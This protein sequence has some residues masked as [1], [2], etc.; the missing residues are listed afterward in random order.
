MEW[1]VC[2]LY[3]TPDPNWEQALGMEGSE[4]GLIAKTFLGTVGSRGSIEGVLGDWQPWKP[5]EF[6]SQ[7]GEAEFMEKARMK[8][9]LP[10]YLDGVAENTLEMWLCSRNIR[11]VLTI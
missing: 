1:T 9:P 6:R 8:T 7:E 2:S 4:V 5:R 10:L 11:I 3:S